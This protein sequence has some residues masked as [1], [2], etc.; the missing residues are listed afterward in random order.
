MFYTNF[1]K[2]FTL[3]ISAVEDFSDP[4]KIKKFTYSSKNPN[5]EEVKV[6]TL[7][8]FQ[9]KTIVKLVGIGPTGYFRNQGLGCNKQRSRLAYTII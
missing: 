5:I 8:A 3:E 4:K 7:S 6:V 1:N 2:K 9:W